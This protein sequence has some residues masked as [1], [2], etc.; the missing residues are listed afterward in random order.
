MGL[1]GLSTVTLRECFGQRW[2]VRRSICAAIL[3]TA[4][5][6]RVPGADGAI[7]ALSL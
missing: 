4:S 7:G 5:F 2:R 1:R 3:I 6:Y